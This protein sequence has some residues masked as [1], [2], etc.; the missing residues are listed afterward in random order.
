M[1]VDSDVALH[2]ADVNAYKGGVVELCY[3]VR[4]ARMPNPHLQLTRA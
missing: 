2:L 3:E 4:G 1:A